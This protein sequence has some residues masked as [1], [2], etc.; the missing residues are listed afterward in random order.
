[1]KRYPLPPPVIILSYNLRNSL[2]AAMEILS[3]LQ[4]EEIVARIIHST[5]T[6][7]EQMIS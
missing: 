7:L 2:P 5:L 1:L 3:Y 4:R 6:E